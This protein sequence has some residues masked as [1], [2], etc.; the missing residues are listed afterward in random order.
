LCNVWP[1]DEDKEIQNLLAEAKQLI[2]GEES[3]HKKEP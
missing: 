3:T 1:F 2:A